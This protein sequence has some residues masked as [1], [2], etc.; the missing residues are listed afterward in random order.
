MRSRP[1]NCARCNAWSTPREVLAR[2]TLRGGIPGV[3]GALADSLSATVVVVD[4][5]GTVL[6]AGGG[7]RERL[8]AVLGEQSPPSRRHGAHVT[9]DGDSYVTIQNLRAAQPVRGRLAVRTPGPMSNADRLLVAHAD[10]HSSRSRSRAGQVVD[11][12]QLL[13][14]AVTRELLCRLQALSTVRCCATSVLSRTVTLWW[15]RSPEQ[16]RCWRPSTSWAVC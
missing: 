4:T 15:R 9:V 7:E 2:A 12:E 13:R 11:A 1:T 8:I 3:V 6:A 5:D 10:R 14:T 16:G